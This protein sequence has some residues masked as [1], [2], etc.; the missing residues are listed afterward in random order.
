MEP[1]IIMLQRKLVKAPENSDKALQFS[2]QSFKNDGLKT[3]VRVT[4]DGYPVL[5]NPLYP[6]QV[7]KGSGN[8]KITDMYWEEIRNLK[9][10]L[11]HLAY[12]KDVLDSIQNE[13]RKKSLRF[14]ENAKELNGIAR[15]I[16]LSD[17]VEKIPSSKELILEIKG[18]PIDFLGTKAMDS[19][20]EVLSKYPNKQ[21]KIC[22]EDTKVMQLFKMQDHN[23]EAG[24]ILNCKLDVQNMPGGL[25][26]LI[27]EMPLVDTESLNKMKEL[28]YTQDRNYVGLSSFSEYKRYENLF[29]EEKPG[30][31]TNQPEKIKQYILK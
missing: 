4:K 23:L 27:T 29:E 15:P 20:L 21:I 2:I 16:L 22:S 24:A 12:L 13:D 17:V 31:I 18:E 14:L 10:P 26:Y 6:Y 3:E 5:F 30:I 11:N 19:I 7:A 8:E 9:L 28:G 1:K 25:D